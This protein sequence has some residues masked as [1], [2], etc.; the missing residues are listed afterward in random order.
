MRAPRPDPV[1]DPGRA[2]S[3]QGFFLSEFLGEIVRDVARKPVGRIRDLSVSTAVALPFPRISGLLLRD[4]FETFVL[5]WEDV[6]IFQRAAVRT[7]LPREELL[8]RPPANDEILLARHLLDKQIVDINGV[9]VVRVN[10]LKLDVLAGDLYL[11]AADVGVRGIVRRVFGAGVTPRGGRVADASLPARLIPWDAMQPLHPKLDRLEATAER[12]A[13]ARL[14][15]AD[16]AEILSQVSTKDR[17]A[18]FAKLDRE[19]AA[20]T[21]HELEPDLQVEIL[22]ELPEKEASE[23]LEQMPPDEAADVLGDLEGEHAREIVGL[24]DRQAA[25][26]V[27]ELLVHDADTAGGLM[28]TAFVTFPPTLTV[29]EALERLRVVA[30]ESETLHYVFVV[31]ESERALG[32][33]SVRDLLAARDE[34]ELAD[35]MSTPVRGVPADAS[36]DEVADTMG[37][38]D[39]LALPVLEADGRLTGI[40]TVDDVLE[41]LQPSARARRRRFT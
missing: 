19:T 17:T 26:D 10:D 29:R 33:A 5:P 40:I 4:R 23:I 34:Q 12:N 27:T 6:A 30:R 31:D 16:I 1:T 35:V 32:A 24:M 15:P 2:P 36:A 21:L 13:I 28:G 18:V 39:L 20:E 9:K 8:H 14:H 7:R 37:K 41:R 38:Y 3:R 11:T 25:E 22:E